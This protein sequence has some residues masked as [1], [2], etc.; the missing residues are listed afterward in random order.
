[1]QPDAAMR[2]GAAEI[3]RLVRTVDGIA[4]QKEDRIGH[5]RAAVDGRAMIAN[6]R[7]GLEG[8][9]RRAITRARRRYRP[10]VARRAVDIDVHA[11]ARQVDLGDDLRLRHGWRE[12]N[13][14]EQ[15]GQDK[16]TAHV[17]SP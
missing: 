2:G 3:F 4:A 9:G 10:G 13:E 17:D 14:A 6:E 7:G 11:L 8:A 1:M 12:T 5:R 16:E 15:S